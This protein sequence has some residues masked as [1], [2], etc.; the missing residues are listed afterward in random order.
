M[1]LT[2]LIRW[3]FKSVESN[4]KTAQ[5]ISQESF[6]KKNY[7]GSDKNNV[8]LQ[9]EAK[10][11]NITKDELNSGLDWIHQTGGGK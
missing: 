2:L 11:V 10:E 7:E 6:Y 9:L 4:T 1:N 3:V 5:V 8:H